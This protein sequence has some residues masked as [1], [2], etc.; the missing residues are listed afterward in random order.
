[1]LVEIS[2]NKYYYVHTYLYVFLDRLILARE[3][4]TI[5]LSNI[6][7]KKYISDVGRKCE[8]MKT[9]Y[10]MKTTYRKKIH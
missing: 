8:M 9:F 1:M 5:S 7:E 10:I 3:S 2:I 6:F 4:E